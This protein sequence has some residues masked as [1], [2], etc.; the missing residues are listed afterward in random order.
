M[1]YAPLK[2]LILPIL[3][4]SFTQASMHASY[5]YS[6]SRV[7]ELR[8]RSTQFTTQAISADG[9]LLVAASATQKKNSQLYTV[10]IWDRLHGRPYFY[11]ECQAP[12]RTA[13]LSS[14]NRYLAYTMSSDEESLELVLI[15]LKNNQKEEPIRLSLCAQGHIPVYLAFSPDNKVIAF[16]YQERGEAM[17]RIDLLSV[18]TLEHTGFARFAGSNATGLSFTQDA[19]HVAVSYK[20]LIKVFDRETIESIPPAASDHVPLLEH[21]VEKTIV[22][23]SYDKDQKNSLLILQ[24][25]NTQRIELST[26]EFFQERFGYCC[27]NKKVFKI[28]LPKEKFFLFSL[29]PDRKIFSYIGIELLSNKKRCQALYTLSRL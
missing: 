16:C 9:A 14:D 29:S 21:R 18:P 10:S 4:I 26:L 23:I 11:Q 15:D 2:A 1:Y 20:H 27:N 25:D 28:D 5:H 6:C 12:V 22:G 17:Q 24:K 7:I 8:E 19:S 3:F 13:A